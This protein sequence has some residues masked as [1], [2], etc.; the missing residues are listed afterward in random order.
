MDVATG[1]RDCPIPSIK[2]ICN[3]RIN[4]NFNFLSQSDENS[5]NS[6]KVA[7]KK[8]LPHSAPYSVCTLRK[9]DAGSLSRATPVSRQVPYTHQR[10]AEGK[11]NSVSCGAMAVFILGS[12][13]QVSQKAQSRR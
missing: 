9:A 5:S 4:V 7:N 6:V 2:S 12:A 3:Y 10:R 8:I 1:G 13:S 11:E